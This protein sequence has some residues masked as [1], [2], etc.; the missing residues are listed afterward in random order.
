MRSWTW[1][2]LEVQAGTGG[3][4]PCAGHSLVTELMVYLP[5]ESLI[6]LHNNIK[7]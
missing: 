3:T 4:T 5:H 6:Q 1:S 2:R 7:N